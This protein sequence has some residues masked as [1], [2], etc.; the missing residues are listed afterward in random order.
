MEVQA[1]LGDEEE[2][3]ELSNRIRING[4][5]PCQ[6]MHNNKCY[7]INDSGPKMAVTEHW[8]KHQLHFRALADT[9]SGA[10][11]IAE[12]IAYSKGM[13]I[14][15]SKIRLAAANNTPINCSGQT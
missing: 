15:K 10:T 9:G 6:D 3:E 11:L 12:N 8:D 5:Q 13:P 4:I 7:K 14:Q 2:M 1:T